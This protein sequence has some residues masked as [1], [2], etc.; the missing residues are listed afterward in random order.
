[1][2]GGDPRLRDEYVA[3][4][5]HWDH[6]GIGPAV[7][8][9]SIYNGALDNASGVADILAVARAAA[10]APQKPK[11]SLAVRLRDGGGVR[12]CS[13]PSS[14]R[15]NPRCPPRESSPTSTWTAAT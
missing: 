5:A 12:A 1:M 14:S 4:S 2:R 13:A 11:R 3:Y 10:A 6:L 8:G 7:N 9:D 15:S